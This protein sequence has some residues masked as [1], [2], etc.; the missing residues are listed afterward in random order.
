MILPPAGMILAPDAGRY[1]ALHPNSA[2][3]AAGVTPSGDMPTGWPTWSAGWPPRKA[4]STVRGRG[5]PAA[6]TKLLTLEDLGLDRLHGERVFVRVDFNV[7]LA[8]GGEVLDA[9]RLEEALPTLRELSRA[10]ARLLLASHC[11]RPKGAPDPRYSLRPV[12]RK[13]AE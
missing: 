6:M 9:T 10:G 8:P 11:G 7:P 5:G 13:L 12:A 2:P 3:A 1:S 4:M